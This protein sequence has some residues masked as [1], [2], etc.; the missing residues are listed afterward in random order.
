MENNPNMEN[1]QEQN[2]EQLEN[3]AA[4]TIEVVEQP[5]DGKP[6]RNIKKEIFD[7]TTSIVAAVIIALVIRTYIFT[8]VRVDGPSMNPTLTHG[9]TLYAQRFM[10]KPANGDIIIFRPPNS[11]ET[12][13]VKR[14]IATAG[15]TVMVDEF[16][17]TVYVDDVALD[18]PYIAEPTLSAGSM[19]YPCTVPEG[20]IFVMGDNR[21]N[22]RDS[23]DSTVGLIPLENV[24]GRAMFRLLPLSGFGPLE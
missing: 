16:T 21:N 3:S 6:V 24:I 1:P 17:H 9:D 19:H 4:E 15:Q 22:S 20:Y 8:L 18:E 14:V 13:Y 12:P 5:V 2:A 10:Y 23:R 11:P 7:W